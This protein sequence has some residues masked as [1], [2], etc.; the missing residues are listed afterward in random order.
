M[1]APYVGPAPL[2]EQQ[3]LFGRD[4]E[5]EELQWRL[6]ADRIIVLYSASGAGKT[7]LLTAKNGLPSQLKTR[8]FTLPILRVG[9]K[10][11]A[12]PVQ[13]ILEQLKAAGH[14]PVMEGDTLLGYVDRIALPQT[15]PP[16][17]LF[18]V[19]DQFE[20]VFSNGI[21]H[22]EQKNFFEQLGALLAR[23]KSPIW[24]VISMREEYFSWLDT[25]RDAVPTRLTNTFRLN[26]LSI[27]QAVAAVKGPAEAINVEFPK[28]DGHDAATYLV[29]E[30]SKVRVRGP[31]GGIEVQFGSKVE[32]V[33]LQ[34]ICLD[35]WKRLSA[36]GPVKAI[37]VADVKEFKPE[38]ALQEYC[39]E[40]LNTVAANPRRASALRDWIDQ[41]LLTRSGL[42][43]PAMLDPADQNC[44]TPDEVSALEEVH[45]IRR[46]SREDGEWY[47]LSHDSL[48]V[49][50]R[51]SIESWRVKHLEAWQQLAR[52]WQ[53]GGEQ[54]AYFKTLPQGSR[55]HIPLLSTDVAYS[56]LEIRFLAAY[57]AYVHHKRMSRLIFAVCAVAAV[58]AALTFGN[59]GSNARLI[60][61]RNQTALYA[62]IFA[63]LSS[64]PRVGLEARAAV[65]GTDLQK[66]K[67]DV[68]AFNARTALADFLN[69]TRHIERV[70]YE[71]ELGSGDKPTSKM[72]VQNH[73]HRVIAAISKQ[74][75]S[76]EVIHR[77][78]SQ[79][80]WKIDLAAL[81]KVHPF[82]LRTVALLGDGRIA[83]GGNDG[84]GGIQ[85][86][87]INTKQTDGDP[88]K[89][90]DPQLWYLG[91]NVRTI[92]AAGGWLY[93]GFE[94]GGV[95]AWNISDPSGRSTQPVWST[96]MDSRISALTTSGDGNSVAIADISGNEQVTLAR[97][98]EVNGKSHNIKFDATPRE[99]DYRGA[100]YSIAISPDGRYI[101]AGSRAG[102]IH[103]WD[104]KKKS[105]VVRFDAHEQ[106]VAQLQYTKE[107]ELLSIGWDG[108]L[109]LWTFSA[110]KFLPPVGRTLVELTRQLV[111]VALDPTTNTAY[112]TTEKGDVL[113]ISLMPDTHPL[114]QILRGGGFL[115]HLVENGDQIHLIAASRTSLSLASLDRKSMVPQSTL[116]IP[117]PEIQ[118][119]ARAELAKTT[120]VA[121]G[122]KVTAFRDNQPDAIPISVL[123]D[124]GALKSIHVNARGTFLIALGTTSTT[125]WSLQQPSL[126]ATDC[127]GSLAHQLKK[128]ARLAIFR[129]SS[130]DFVFISNSLNQY[131]KV[132]ENPSG[133][134]SI[135]DASMILGQQKAEIQTAAFNPSGT[136][137]WAGDYTGQVYSVE[138]DNATP[139]VNIIQLESTTPPSAMAVNA[140]NTVVV[141]DTGGGLY[142]FEEKSA[143]PIKI[144]QDF[145]DSDIRSVA[146]SSDGKWV[147][148]SSSAGTAIWNLRLDRWVTRACAL[149]AS[150]TFSKS[151]QETYFNRVSEKP[152][153]CTPPTK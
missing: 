76:V 119:M 131:W 143:L 86:W 60:I 50:V 62:G 19:I 9:G 121:Q 25:F 153:P 15:Q 4:A 113:N 114:G 59:L 17:R 53:L 96:R 118:G 71:Y 61:E 44:P 73:E 6:I 88:L 139:K 95:G 97:G 37:R 122:G 133:C 24:A 94:K 48:A 75:Y 20:E 16:K 41:R 107:G 29:R 141:G 124:K 149:A 57:R 142:L 1:S 138:L 47:E 123:P 151:D 34:V 89:A 66:D 129:P 145:H 63:I 116:H 91:G 5:L 21:S 93:A 136:R 127:T 23:E 130:S 126:T 103:V 11:G 120:F 40:A 14:G 52:A 146:I 92:T 43:A 42:R 137:L 111:S 45:L 81:K 54:E 10:H 55:Q 7:S 134:P 115:S 140:S 30:L 31:N 35:L 80:V 27:E 36:K 64:H 72:V 83:T 18:M 68:V 150:R 82:G 33:Q 58:C 32:A 87:D 38:S 90:A 110:D 39:N 85:I 128:Q 65:A 77:S 67:N 26:L 70:E 12:N 125:M 104:I 22:D 2:G 78:G 99:D 102:R 79:P 135:E 108:R 98:A 28:E 49:P 117:L 132:R 105:H 144:A 148:S 13:A 101:A 152:T 56:E 46:Q 74:H 69:R 84:D 106:A 147:I 112:V 3:Q 109:K 100:F 51:M 8:F